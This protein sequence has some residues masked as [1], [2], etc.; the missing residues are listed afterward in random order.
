MMKGNAKCIKE[1]LQEYRVAVKNGYSYYLEEHKIYG[2][3]VEKKI[4]GTEKTKYVHIYY[5]GIKAEE[6]KIAINE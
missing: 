1:I 5:D 3:A 6:E 2:M 4:F